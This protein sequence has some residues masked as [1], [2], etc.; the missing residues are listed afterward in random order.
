MSWTALGSFVAAV[1][2]R[3][4]GSGCQNTHCGLPVVGRTRVRSSASSVRSGSSR[5]SAGRSVEIV[6]GGRRP[7][8]EAGWVRHNFVV[9]GLERQSVLPIEPKSSFS[10]FSFRQLRE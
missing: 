2:R 7:G 6:E 10:S 5:A 4:P 9:V 8:T 3:T 1:C